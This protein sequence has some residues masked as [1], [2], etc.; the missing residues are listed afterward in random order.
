MKLQGYSEEF[1]TE[2]QTVFRKGLSCPDPTFC[3][4]LLIVKRREY[5]LETYLFLCIMEKRLTVY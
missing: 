5:N 4:K 1:I 3:L 2:T